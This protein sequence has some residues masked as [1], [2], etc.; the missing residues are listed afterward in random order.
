MI[1]LFINSL[2]N[3]CRKNRKDRH[4]Q[5]K[6][7][8]EIVVVVDH[9]VGVAAD[10][11]AVLGH[12]VAVD[13]AAVVVVV[14]VDVAVVAVDVVASAVVDDTVVLDHAVA[15]DVVVVAVAAAVADV[16][17]VVVAADNHVLSLATLA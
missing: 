15:D 13:V 5:H 8:V 1:V 9:A 17:A 2:N 3:R 11:T 16:A 14:A 12:A 4:L 6:V 10:D 7:L